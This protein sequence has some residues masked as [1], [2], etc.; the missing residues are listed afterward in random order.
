M[1]VSAEEAI[2]IHDRQIERFGG[3]PGLRDEGALDA[4]L[5]SPWQTFGGAEL[6]LTDAEKAARLP[7]E[8]ITQHPF[9]DANKRTGA[10]LLVS[11]MRQRGHRFEPKHEDLYEAILSVADGTLGYEGLLAFVEENAEPQG[12]LQS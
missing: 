3:M 12:S 10:V 6:Y 9:A 8:I 4:A 7:F 5:K 2:A 1:T 11:F